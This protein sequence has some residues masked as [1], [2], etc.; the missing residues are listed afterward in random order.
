MDFT[1]GFHG[2]WRNYES[3]Q[4]NFRRAGTLVT[5]K[6]YTLFN[7]PQINQVY[8]MFLSHLTEPVFEAG[9]ESLDCKLCLESEI[10][11][12]QIA[13][14]T[15]TYSLQLF[16][17][18]RTAGKFSMHIGDLIREESKSKLKNLSSYSY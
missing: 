3:G 10:P 8:M 17:K 12:D 15:I 7:L 6:L 1:C 4:G 14:P 5:R 18:D 9:E 11:W 16:F 13:F 2:E